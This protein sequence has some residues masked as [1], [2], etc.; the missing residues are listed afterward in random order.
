M[1]SSSPS[2]LPFVR[3]GQAGALSPLPLPSAKPNLN[4]RWAQKKEGDL[5]GIALVLSELHGN[6]KKGL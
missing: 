5:S 1:S 3:W 2:S 4:R 6:R